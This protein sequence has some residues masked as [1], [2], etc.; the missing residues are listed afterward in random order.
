M[1]ATLATL[2]MLA[3]TLAIASGSLA[4]NINFPLYV[5]NYSGFT[6]KRARQHFTQE[7]DIMSATLHFITWE[8]V[9]WTSHAMTAL[10][11]AMHAVSLATSC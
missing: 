10:S 3:T 8:Y 4:I 5:Y 11:L 1:L 6:R 2:A 9:C 7:T